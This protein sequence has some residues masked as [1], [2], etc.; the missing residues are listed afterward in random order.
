MRRTRGEVSF[1]QADANGAL[2]V[3]YDAGARIALV[4][5]GGFANVMRCAAPE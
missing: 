3:L 4:R 1:L 5:W 2:S